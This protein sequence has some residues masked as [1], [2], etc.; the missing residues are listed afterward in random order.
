M[1]P[2]PKNDNHIWRDLTEEEEEKNYFPDPHSSVIMC[3]RC[4]LKICG[5]CG[6][7]DPGYETICAMPGK[8]F[9]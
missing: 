9:P 6:E 8:T 3:D 7:D 4:H 5:Y 2:K 1:L